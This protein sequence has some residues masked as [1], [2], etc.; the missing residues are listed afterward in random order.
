MINIFAAPLIVRR[1]NLWVQWIT[2]SSSIHFTNTEPEKK[3]V[4]KFTKPQCF[5]ISGE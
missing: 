1:G 4:Y 2:T 5:R 3:S